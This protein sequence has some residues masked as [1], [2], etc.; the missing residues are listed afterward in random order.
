M[1]EEK[2]T[3]KT[4]AYTPVFHYDCIIIQPRAELSFIDNML[5]VNR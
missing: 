3:K 1:Y 2:V 5:F 4:G